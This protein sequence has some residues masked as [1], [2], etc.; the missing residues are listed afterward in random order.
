MIF[1]LDVYRSANV[2]IRE[3]GADVALE[4]ASED[5]RMML[6]RTSYEPA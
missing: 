2:P 1:D 4:A 5:E 3:H 6:L